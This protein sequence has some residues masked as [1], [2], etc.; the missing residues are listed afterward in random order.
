ME[1]DRFGQNKHYFII[2]IFCL[3][4]GVILF[5]VSFYSFPNLVLNWKYNIPPT[6]ALVSQYLQYA[7]HLKHSAA[8]W[9]VFLIS[10]ALSIILFII[11]D[12]LSNKIDNKIYKEHYGMDEVEKPVKKRVK[13]GEDRES[14]G[15]VFKIIMIIILVFIV[16]EFFQWAITI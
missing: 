13:V 4:F 2:G 6:Y 5:V 8:G 15:L 11:A 16:S 3:V 14:R 9:L 1:A 12:I 10:F 7:Y